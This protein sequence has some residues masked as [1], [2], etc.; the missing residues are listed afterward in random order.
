MAGVCVLLAAVESKAGELQASPAT[1]TIQNPEASQQVLVT[2]LADGRRLDRTRSVRFETLPQ[3]VISVDDQGLVRPLADG[4][5]ELIIHFD[6]QRLSVPVEVSGMASPPP[7]SFRNE[8]M[9]ILTKAKCN[10]GGCHGKA[11]GQNG[12]KL[13]I[14]GYDAKTDHE[15]LTIESRGRRV[16]PAAPEHSLVYLKGSARIP[17]GG[18]RKIEPGSFRDRLLLR[19]IAEG[20][21]FAVADDESTVVVGIEVE[22]QDQV[23]LAGESQ[24]L[25]V[26]AI[27][28][29]GRRR[30]VTAETEF[31]S[32]ASAIAES[33][34]QGLVQASDIPGEAAILVRHLGHVAV[35][36]ITLP[37]PGVE[38]VAPPQNNFIDGLVWEKL[39]RLGIQPSELS[40]DATFLRRVYLDTI[41]TLPTAEEARA[42][43]ADNSPN[44]RAE[45]I[46]RVLE[47]PEYVDYWTMKW[48][49]ILRADQ[50]VISPQ[51]AVA[52]QRWLK[53]GLEENKPYDQFARELLTVQ[54]N[55][56]AEG[57]GS[58][59]KAVTKP[60]EAARSLSQLLLGVRIE[61]AQCHHHPSERW[62]QSD[63]VALAGFFTGLKLKKL[64][65]GE[66]GLV[67]QGGKD[68]PHPRHGELIPAAALGA[69]VADFTGV[70]DRRRVLADWLTQP[71]NAFFAKA[72]SNRLW[73]HYLGR[74]LIEPIDDIRDTN[75]ATNEPLME[76]L[77]QHLI[78]SK[79]DLKAFTRTV[80]NSRVYQL[81][82]RGNPSNETDV[83]N[84][85]HAATKSLPAEVLL[86]AICQSTAVDEKYNGWPAGYRAI[87]IWDNRMPSYFFTIFGRPVRATVCECE[88]SNEPSI[89]QAL[90]LLNAPE[91]AEKIGHREGRIRRLAASD[92][93]PREIIAE[94]YLTTLTR[95]PTDEE[96]TLMQLA[97]D[98]PGA[99]RRTAS[100]DVLWALMNSKE[101]VFNH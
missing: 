73:A 43:L 87:Q 9:P 95:F 50:L 34:P 19:W 51:G 22:P 69:P 72:I 59:Y 74:G 58:F 84:F 39:D 99:D 65:N 53:H 77:S 1:I 25:R 32:N 41:G 52:M 37:R 33:S 16:F 63:Y 47:R 85:S 31:E 10:S 54:G 91:I 68:L 42:F 6:K 48:L 90:H 44:K 83:Q 82:S 15:A 49:D 80:L 60:D 3:G 20:G 18:G 28:A 38:V 71:D 35:C 11:E 86:D 21:Q 8:V 36:R 94:L 62:S 101:F 12:F 23:L 26:T 27:D 100:E 29:A 4:A 2:E 96:I 75:P 46:D 89:S 98:Q 70:S 13:S 7:V 76:A 30:C 88:R 40:D 61:C 64:P 57:P 67:S 66:Q 97:F 56:S 24:Q 81:A 92:L 45:V 14:F 93:T 5:A 55:T 78:D 17:H 79:F